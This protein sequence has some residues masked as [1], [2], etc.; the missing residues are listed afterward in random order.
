MMPVSFTMASSESAARLSAG[1]SSLR[2]AC[3]R[4]VKR[5]VSM[6]LTVSCVTVHSNSMFAAAD[7]V[8]ACRLPCPDAP[9]FLFLQPPTTG[10]VAFV[11][12]S[13]MIREKKT[14]ERQDMTS[15]RD[16]QP[17]SSR[18]WASK[19]P[20]MC[21]D[22]FVSEQRFHVAKQAKVQSMSV[23]HRVIPSISRLRWRLG[24]NSRQ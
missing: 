12:Y 22:P 3:S 2:W 15:C 7:R 19:V 16:R 1:I 18:H 14:R 24:F 9:F 23:W 5:Y 17:Q 10:V 11:R 20:L 6:R 8:Y 21:R 4:S 13:L